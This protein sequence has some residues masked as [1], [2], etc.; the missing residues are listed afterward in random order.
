MISLDVGLFDF[1]FFG[2]LCSSHNQISV[3]FFRLG[4]FLVIISLNTFL[5]TF[6]SSASGT[7]IMCKL[8]LLWG[9]VFAPSPSMLKFLGQGLNLYHR[10]NQGHGCD[11]ARSLI[12]W[13]TRDLLAHFKNYSIDHLCCSHFF[14][15][16]FCLLFWWDNYH[17]LFSRSLIHYSVSSSQL[18]IASWVLFNSEIKLSSL[19]LSLYFLLPC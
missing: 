14:P 10:G 18:L 13:A 1:I 19:G 7:P 9:I 3:F 15:F 6:L 8:A 5:V 2:T 16:V 11:N 17:Y 4:N 12:Y